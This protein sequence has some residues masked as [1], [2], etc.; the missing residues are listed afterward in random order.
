[1]SWIHRYP[2]HVL[3]HGRPIRTTPDGRHYYLDQWGHPILEYPDDEVDPAAL[4]R[5]EQQK[6]RARNKRKGEDH[7]EP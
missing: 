3:R 7:G 6:Q 2:W 1:M 5:W 4:A